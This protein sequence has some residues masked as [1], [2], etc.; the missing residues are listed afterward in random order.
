[1]SQNF[2]EKKNAKFFFIFSKIFLRNE[3]DDFIFL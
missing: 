2:L 1:M 3:T